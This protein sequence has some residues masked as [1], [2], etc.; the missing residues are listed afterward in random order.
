MGWIGDWNA[1]KTAFIGKYEFEDG[2][3]FD[4]EARWVTQ[5]TIVHT[6]PDGYTKTV[7]TPVEPKFEFT[8]NWSKN[9]FGYPPVM[10]PAPKK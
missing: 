8:G 7:N 4:G 10:P 2:A 3:I 6:T 9:G 5:H 1:D